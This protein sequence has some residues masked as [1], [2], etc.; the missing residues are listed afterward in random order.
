MKTVLA[1]DFG[2]SSGRAIK[3]VF[4][5]ERISYDEIHRFENIPINEDGHIFH[6]VDMILN[7]IDIAIDKAGEVDTL[8]FDTWGVD[9]GLID[10]NGKL[11]NMPYHYR[12]VRTDNALETANSIMPQSQLYQRTGNQ[13]MQ[14]N[15]CF[16]LSV[17]RIWIRQRSYCL[18]PICSVI[19]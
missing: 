16:S 2:A 17:I 12:D 5:G 18:C 1:F 3:A 7:E 19:F 8:A 15:T 6:N 14:I 10:E 11:V 4:D 13:V 9:Y